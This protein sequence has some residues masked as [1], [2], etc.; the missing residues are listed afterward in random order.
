[1]LLHASACPR[2]PGCEVALNRR[3]GRGM[4]VCLCVVKVCVRAFL[5]HAGI[6]VVLSAGSHPE[7]TVKAA[8]Q[9]EQMVS[10]CVTRSAG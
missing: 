5:C 4:R 2:P 3:T 6:S 1:M 7:G 9:R 10:G 8:S